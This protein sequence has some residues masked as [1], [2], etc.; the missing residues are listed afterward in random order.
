QWSVGLQR[1]IIPNLVMEAAYVGNRGAWFTSPILDPQA[2]NGL[3][4][5]GLLAQRKYGATTGLDV[6]DP[7]QLALLTSPISS[8][9]VIAKF[10][11]LA[12]P[13]NVYPGFPSYEPLNQALRPVPQWV[14]VPP[15]LGPPNGDTWYDSLQVKLTKRYSHGLTINGSYTWQKELVLGVNSATPYFTAGSGGAAP[16]QPGPVVVND[17]NNRMQNKQISSLERP[18]VL[19]LTFN[20]TTP[21]NKFG[22][23]GAGAKTLQ[24]VTRDWSIGGVL[25]YQSGQLLET[26][27]ANNNFLYQ[28]GVG[29]Q[30]NPALFSSPQG[31]ENYVKGQPFFTP[32]FDPNSHFDP[33]KTQVLNPNAWT[34]PGPAQFGVSA[35]Y[36]IQNRWQRQPGESLSVARSFR[37]KE[38]YTI[39]VRAEFQNIFNRVFYTAPATGNGTGTATA[40]AFNNPFPVAGSSS[41]ALSAG[42]GYVN[43]FNGG[44]PTAPITPRTGQILARFTF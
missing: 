44:P 14:G 40:L 9:S 8:P 43:M 3:T 17:V 5:A 7:A 39:Q 6:N 24:W 36:Y 30:D 31:V 13:N 26:P 23:D 22:G 38:K 32:G 42:Y 28:L 4:P 35:P 16:G 1:E 2:E 12:N 21:K 41:G 29:S 10:P 15:F 34:Q 25:R 11:A 19:T 37:I 20:Y 33:T 18:Q 27:S